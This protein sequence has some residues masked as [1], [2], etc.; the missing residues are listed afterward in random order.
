MTQIHLKIQDQVFG[1]YEPSQVDALLKSGQISGETLCCVEGHGLWLPIWKYLGHD[2]QAQLD[3]QPAEAAPEEAT[4]YNLNWRDQ[5]ATEKQKAKLCHF[6]C[7]WDEGITKGQASDA[8]TECSRLYPDLERDWQNQP[9][10]AEQIG[11]LKALEA[12][13]E[14][15]ITHGEASELIDEIEISG[16]NAS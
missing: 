4:D 1:P 3:S 12:E 10:S 7:S 16:S 11:H 14:P 2:P 8:L 15:S 6:G 13:F 5:P 9:A